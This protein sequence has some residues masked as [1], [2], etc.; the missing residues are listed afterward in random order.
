M[1]FVAGNTLFQFSNINEITLVAA[2]RENK[3]KLFSLILFST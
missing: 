3:T 2:T 1:L